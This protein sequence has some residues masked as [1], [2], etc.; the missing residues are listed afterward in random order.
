MLLTMEN[1]K[2][3]KKIEGIHFRPPQI[4]TVSPDYKPYPVKMKS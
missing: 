1:H 4:A 3:V 2:L